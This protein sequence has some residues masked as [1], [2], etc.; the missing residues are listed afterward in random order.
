MVDYR[1]DSPLPPP[2]EDLPGDSSRRNFIAK[3][4]LA[5]AGLAA[6]GA[7]LSPLFNAEEIPSIEELLQKHYKRLTDDDKKAIFARLEAQI[8]NKYN[9]DAHITDPQPLDGVEFAYVLNIGRCIGCRKCV[10]ACM[11]ENNTARDP[12]IQYIRVLKLKKGL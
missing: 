8:K 10:Y 12:Q 2:I 9:I 5:V 4:A 3:G 11:K 7:A 1:D 6:G